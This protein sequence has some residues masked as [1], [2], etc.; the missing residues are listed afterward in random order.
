MRESQ[1]L[2]VPT[3]MLHPVLSSFQHTDVRWPK[4]D[5][6]TDARLQKPNPFSHRD[7]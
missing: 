7:P 6:S 2:D 3:P 5:R 1:V 4:T